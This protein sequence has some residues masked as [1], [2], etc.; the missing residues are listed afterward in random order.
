M[1]INFFKIFEDK[2]NHIHIINHLESIGCYQDVQIELVLYNKMAYE[3]YFYDIEEQDEYYL[4]EVNVDTPNVITN[5]RS[6]KPKHY[7]KF[8]N[9]LYKLTREGKIESLKAL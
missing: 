7:H 2:S 6:M 1:Q 8:T 5:Y 4:M 3:I 9:F